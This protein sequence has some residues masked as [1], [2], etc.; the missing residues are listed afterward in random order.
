VVQLSMLGLRARLVFCAGFGGGGGAGRAEL[1]SPCWGRGCRQTCQ[2]THP[3]L[4]H[5]SGTAAA[6]RVGAQIR[7]YVWNRRNMN[8]RDVETQDA[9]HDLPTE[10]LSVTPAQRAHGSYTISPSAGA[11]DETH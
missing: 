11:L 2:P 9:G 3:Y 4:R 7:Q 6:R 10:L 5:P 1:L 8:A